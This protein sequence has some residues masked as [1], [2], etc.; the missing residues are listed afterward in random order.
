MQHEHEESGLWPFFTHF[1]KYADPLKYVGGIASAFIVAL[2][3]Y[4]AWSKATAVTAFKAWQ[5]DLAKDQK[6]ATKGDDQQTLQCKAC[7]ACR[8]TPAEGCVLSVN[9]CAGH[10]TRLC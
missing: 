8:P 3:G 5:A 10:Y 4:T 1:K 9:N 2:L 7:F 6:F